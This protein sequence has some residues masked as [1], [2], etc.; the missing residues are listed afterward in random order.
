MPVGAGM[1]SGSRAD[2][3]RFTVDRADSATLDRYFIENRSL[4]SEIAITSR[5]TRTALILDASAS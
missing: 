3:A 2:P 4:L 5:R 1:S